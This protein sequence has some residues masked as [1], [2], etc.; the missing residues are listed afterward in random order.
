M[1]FFNPSKRTEVEADLVP[2]VLSIPDIEGVTFSGGEPFQQADLL[3]LFC[4]LVKKERPGFSIGAY[5]GY[6]LEELR[7]GHWEWR[8]PMM[9]GYAQGIPKGAEALLQHMDFI[10]AGRF[11]EKLKCSDKPLCGSSNQQVHF[12]TDRY[13]PVDLRPNAVE[14]ILDADADL[15]QITGFPSNVDQLTAE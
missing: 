9:L 10:V 1:Q 12:L 8:L 13:S 4:D 6:T 14:M 3:A 2:W 11:N 7:T 15:L 5:T